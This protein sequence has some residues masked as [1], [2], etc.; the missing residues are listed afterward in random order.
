LR[1]HIIKI[2]MDWYSKIYSVVRWS[3]TLSRQE[4][5]KSG[6]RQRGILSPFLFNIY[7]DSLITRLRKADLGCHMGRVF[8]GVIAYA[9]DLLLVSASVV[10]LQR[11]C[12]I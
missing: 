8:V 10:Q 3:D 11:E 9:D 2:L 5:V 6:I 7:M 4:S 1:G 12:L